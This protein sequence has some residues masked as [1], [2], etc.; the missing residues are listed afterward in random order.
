[1]ELRLLKQSRAEQSKVHMK[2]VHTECEFVLTAWAQIAVTRRE[3]LSL[4]VS[5][6]LSFSLFLLVLGA[7][8]AGGAIRVINIVYLVVWGP[9]ILH[10][11]S[12]WQGFALVIYE[13]FQSLDFVCCI[14]GGSLKASPFRVRGEGAVFLIGILV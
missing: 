8:P 9:R 14:E 1:M 10:L 12:K 3:C 11:P 4:Y 6:W 13:Y 5:L 2:I 7:R